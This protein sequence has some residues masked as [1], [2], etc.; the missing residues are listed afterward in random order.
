MTV[1]R[2]VATL[3][4]VPMEWEGNGALAARA[5]AGMSLMT[6]TVP[7]LRHCLGS[8]KDCAD[9]YAVLKPILQGML[10]SL[11]VDTPSVDLL[12]AKVK[13]FLQ[14]SNYPDPAGI[15]TVAH[16]DAWSIKRSLSTLK[17]KWSRQEMPK[18]CGDKLYNGCIIAC[19]VHVANRGSQN[20]PPC[21]HTNYPPGCPCPRAGGDV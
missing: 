2:R 11:T 5:R 17:R 3:A 14:L 15:N 4:T 20:K 13:L 21:M 6:P 8:L 10:A 16:R 9:N 12:G 7:G 1:I 19:P 18:D